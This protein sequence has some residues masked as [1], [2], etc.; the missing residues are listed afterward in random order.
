MQV[1]VFTAGCCH[2]KTTLSTGCL[3]LVSGTRV[4]ACWNLTDNKFL[5]R[6]ERVNVDGTYDIRYDDGEGPGSVV[7]CLATSAASLTAAWQ[8]APSVSLSLSLS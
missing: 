8:S 7:D 6:I 1:R 4:I 2:P 5:G 3:L